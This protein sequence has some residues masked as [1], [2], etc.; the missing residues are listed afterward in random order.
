MAM[1]LPRLMRR[2]RA[3]IRPGTLDRELD[4]EI[5]LHLELEAEEIRQ[6]EGVSQA[7]A[8]RRALI[9]FGGVERYREEHRDARGVTWIEN[10]LQDLRYAW[11]GLRNR[12][13][14]SLAVI[15]TLALGIGANTAMF[16]IVD[17]LLFRPPPLMRH[18][19]RVHRV[20][21]RRT[22]H[23]EA[24]ATSYLPY[25]RFVDLT[26]DTRSF[27]RTAQF[28][29]EDLAIGT[30]TDAREMKVGVISATLFGFFDAPPVLGR[31]FTP[32]EDR[33][34]A[35][36]NVAVLSYGFWETRYG[37][38]ADVLGQSL[39]IGAV[40]YTIIGVAAKGFVGMWP[41]AP[42]AAFVPLT[43]SGAEDGASFARRG[44]QWWTTYQWQWAQ[45]L[46]ERK[47]GVALA[48][49]NADLSQAFVRSY[50]AQQQN[51]KGMAPV[52]VANPHATAESVLAER[53]PDESS[54]AKVATW[55]GGVALIVWLIACANVANLL[56]ARAL[57]RRREVAIRLALGV[58]RGRLAAQ[59]LTESVLLALLGGAAGLAVAQWGGALLRA[60][61]L[62]DSSTAAVA[63]DPRTVI[64]AVAAA[65]VAGL[66]IGLAP[67]LQT[68]RTSLTRD[69]RE[70]ARE[71]TYQ[72]SGLRAA[73]LVLQG[74][75]SVVL[76]VGAG[77][78]V[79][80]LRHVRAV[81]L[82]FEP[83]HVALIDLN[84]R[85][86]SLDSVS[87][88]LLLDR[89]RTAAAA[90]PGVTAAARQLTTPFWSTWSLGLK[91]AG[92]DSVDR[93]GR[94]DL[95]A[96]SPEYFE[97]MGTRILKGRGI[98]KTDIAGAPRVMVVSQAMAH[99][100]WPQADPVGQCIRVLERADQE[101]APCSEV[102]GVAENIKNESFAS[103]APVNSVGRGGDQA[104]HD[105]GYFYYLSAAQFLPDQGGL[106]VRLRGSPAAAKEQLRRGLQP[107]M[108]GSAYITVTPLSDIVGQQT[109][110]WRLGATM[111]VLFGVLAL[112]LAAIGLYSVI[113]FNVGQRTHELGVRIALGAQMRDVVALVMTGGIKLALLGL[114]LGAAVALLLSRWVEPLLFDESARDPT[115][116]VVVAGVLL[117][118]AALA[119]FIPARRA[120]RV[121]PMRALRAE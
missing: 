113:A 97:T 26:G 87:K 80:S 35:G 108:P 6:R 46:V 10:R 111:F 100:L 11:R 82:G 71:G 107:L 63:R 18:A 62:S 73:L 59:L 86:E 81:P 47:P 21:L 30:G 34:P 65:V 8:R 29:E 119:S 89:L 41:D 2:L 49:A 40:R 78:F 77:L 60:E 85:G 43:T 12:P 98:D 99:V 57:Q 9:A 22:W 93:L 61:F 54:L 105:P 44:Q 36:T 96:V 68:R 23:G 15:L 42:P 88:A 31:Y 91:V 37:G 33:P 56:L 58:G 66:L 50:A 101:D 83:S 104:G 24:D 25:A 110:P 116:F 112:V 70:G 74:T 3:L 5:R 79:R 38:R 1:H 17:R 117:V 92:I 75:L 27:S 28:T 103:I 14:F 64:Y 121:D 39:Q 51:R 19:D 67:L 48:Q 4:A 102:V 55:T 69:L 90:L 53:G 16:S 115:V 109:Q 76:L 114:A 32:S 94:F 120:A 45:M 118:V 95:N 20:Y 72:R 52:S 84:L 13:G 106:D 7:E